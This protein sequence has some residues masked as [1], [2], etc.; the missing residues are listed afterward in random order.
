ME[1]SC[2]RVAAYRCYREQ[3]GTYWTMRRLE[4]LQWE[5]LY[6]LVTIDTKY[7]GKNRH[8]RPTRLRVLLT[9]R[10]TLCASMRVSEEN[11][12]LKVL[13]QF[14]AKHEEY[15][16]L[17]HKFPQACILKD[18]LPL[19]LIN[20][21]RKTFAADEVLPDCGFKLMHPKEYRCSWRARQ[22]AEAAGYIAVPRACAD[23]ALVAALSLIHI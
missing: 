5:Y 3:I 16:R 15:A 2:Q 21:Y 20:A 1:A 7:G 8:I 10:T 6:G 14:F 9:L 17:S 22:V 13:D 11:I 4:R 18:T 12:P 19:H 23:A